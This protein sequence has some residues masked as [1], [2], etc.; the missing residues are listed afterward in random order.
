MKAVCMLLMPI[1]CLI[2]ASA[3]AQRM[4]LPDS[5]DVTIRLHTRYPKNARVDSVYVIFDRYDLSGAGVIK[6]IY[7][8][9]NNQI[10]IPRVPEGRYYISI[11]CMGRHQ[12]LFNDLTFINRRRSNNLQYNL[13]RS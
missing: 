3:T 2:G 9:V 12:Q 7:Y 10:S 11:F 13:T 5:V 1:L 4:R 8:P 6:R